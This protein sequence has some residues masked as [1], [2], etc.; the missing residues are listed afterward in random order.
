MDLLDVLGIN[1]IPFVTSSYSSGILLQTAAIAPQRIS[2]AILH[3]PS[4]IAHGS[5]LKIMTKLMIPWILYILFPNQKRLIKAFSPMMTELNDDFLKFSDIMLR[6]YKM[7]MRGPREVRK[8]ELRNFL[9]PTF[10]IAARDDIFFPAD[11][12]I[13]K[14]K[15]IFKNLTKSVYIEGKHLSSKKTLAY[16]NKLIIEFLIEN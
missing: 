4:G 12:V 13:P 5:V 10:I 1:S 6:T 14:A 3:V 8:E 7:E 2:H 16:V 15:E 9:A 11:K